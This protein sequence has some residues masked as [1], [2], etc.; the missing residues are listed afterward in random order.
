[1]LLTLPTVASGAVVGHWP[2]DGTFAD[3]ESNG[4]DLA[5]GAAPA[6]AGFASGRFGQAGSFTNDSVVAPVNAALDVTQY[7]VQA[8]FKTPDAARGVTPYPALA[9]RQVDADNRQLYLGW[10]VGCA[11]PQSTAFEYSVSSSDGSRYQVRIDGAPL[12]DGEWHHAAAVAEGTSGG[13]VLRLYVDGVLRGTTTGGGTIELQP[14]QGLRIGDGYHG[15]IDDIRFDDVALTA[16]V[17]QARY[18]ADAPVASG[19]QL[20]VGSC[21]T[22]FDASLFSTLLVGTP[23]VTGADCSIAFGSPDS[24]ATLRM[25]QADG[26]GSAMWQLAHGDSLDAAFGGG[27]PTADVAFGAEKSRA[28][29]VDA[30]R[31]RIYVAGET[32]N[33]G[34]RNSF[35]AA[36]QLSTGLPDTTFAGGDVN[37]SY[38]PG[39]DLFNDIV[40]QPD[41]KV[42]VVGTSNNG[43]NDDVLVV[44]YRQDGSTDTSFSTDGEIEHPLGTGQDEAATVDLLDDGRLVVAGNSRQGAEQD[45]FVMRLHPDGSFDRTF[46]SDGVAF[47]DPSTDEGSVSGRVQ[48]DGRIVLAGTAGS[49]LVAAR[50][51]TDGS[52]DTSYS[53]DGLV[54]VST[55]A[56]PESWEHVALTPDGGLVV[57]GFQNDGTRDN[58]AV[59]KLDAD[60]SLDAD[61]GSNGSVRVPNG[62]AWSYARDV[63][64]APQGEVVVAVEDG[65]GNHMITRLT[66]DGQLD[67]SFAGDGVYSHT[68]GTSGRTGGVA[69]GIDG[70]V[71]AASSATVGPESRTV[72]LMLDSSRIGDYEDGIADWDTAGVNAFGACIRRLSAATT[73]T[74]GVDAN[75]TCTSVDTDPWRSI[76]ATAADGGHLARTTVDGTG[77]AR[78][79]VRFGVRSK[80]GDANGEYIAPVVVEVAAPNL[81]PPVNIDL[82]TLS[83]TA[84]AKTSLG[85]MVGRWSGSPVI[86]YA[87]QWRRCDAAGTS[88]VDIPGATSR[89]FQLTP[90][91]VGLRVRVRVTAANGEGS[92]SADSAVSALVVA[93][94]TPQLIFNTGFEHGVVG[95]TAGSGRRLWDSVAG[96][97][98]QTAVDAFSDLVHSGDY[99][100]RMTTPGGTNTRL[101]INPFGTARRGVVR[102]AVNITRLPSV[103]TMEILQMQT[104]GGN[105]P[106]LEVYAD[107]RIAARAHTGEGTV[108]GNITIEEGRW[109]TIDLFLNTSTPTLT[110]DWMVDGRA[111]RQTSKAAAASDVTGLDLGVDDT[112]AGPSVEAYF[113]DLAIS[114]TAADYPLSYGMNIGLSPDWRIP[115]T[116][117]EGTFLMDGGLPLDGFSEI[118]RVADDPLTNNVDYVYQ[119]SAGGANYLEWTFTN[120][121]PWPSHNANGVHG[122]AAYAATASV[123]GNVRMVEADGSPQTPMLVANMSNGAAN[124]YSGLGMPV[125]T[126]GVWDSTEIADL[127]M[128]TGYATGTQARWHGLMYEVDYPAEYESNTARPTVSGVTRE[129]RDLTLSDGEWSGS[130][131]ALTYWWWRCDGSGRACTPIGATTWSNTYTLA[132][133]DV[134]TTI[135]GMVIATYGAGSTAVQQSVRTAATTVV[136]PATPTPVYL[137]GFETGAVSAAGSGTAT[138]SFDTLTGGAH[139][140]VVSGAPRTGGY[141]LKAEKSAATAA[142]ALYTIPAPGTAVTTRV[143][144]RLD[145]PSTGAEDAL[146]DL[147]DSTGSSF[148]FGV[149]WNRKRFFVDH[150]A[151]VARQYSTGIVEYG[152]WYVI[153]LRATAAVA[154][155]WR[156]DW[157]IDGAPQQT[158]VYTATASTA[159]QVSVAVGLPSASTNG[160][161]V[162]FDDLVVSKT[163]GDYPLGF[164]R[165]LGLRPNATGAHSL[166]VGQLERG[167]AGVGGAFVDFTTLPGSDSNQTGGTNTWNDLDDTPFGGVSDLIRQNNVAAHAE[168]QLEDTGT[169]QT[170]NAVRMV[171][172]HAEQAALGGN[173]AMGLVNL[174]GQVDTAYSIDPT[175]TASYYGGVRIARPAGAGGGPWTGTDVDQVRLR[176]GSSNAGSGATTRPLTHAIMLEADF[177]TGTPPFAVQN[178]SITFAGDY[179]RVGTALHATRGLWS[180]DVGSW[181]YEWERCNSAGVCTSVGS[182]QD[183]YSPAV[184]DLG[185]TIRV[186]VTANSENGAGSRRSVETPPIATAAPTLDW[187]TGFE[188]QVLAGAGGGVVTSATP[189]SAID[190]TIVRSGA[191][192]A[193]FTA[194]GA[195]EEVNVNL[196]APS[197]TVTRFALRV[198]QMPSAQTSIIE[199]PTA[200]LNKPR[201][202]LYPTGRLAAEVA[203]LSTPGAQIQ[204]GRWYVVDLRVDT[205]GATWS[206]DWR[207]DGQPMPTLRRTGATGTTMNALRFGVMSNVTSTVRFDDVAI[208]TNQYDYPIGDGKI[209]GYTVDSQGTHIDDVGRFSHVGGGAIDSTTHTRLDDVP[210]TSTADAVEQTLAHANSYLEFG[211]ANPAETTNP[212]AVRGVLA[213]RQSAASSLSLTARAVR[214][215][216]ADSAAVA[217][218]N[219]VATV[220]QTAQQYLGGMITAPS[221]GWTPAEL[222]ALRLRLGYFGTLPAQPRFQSVMV[223][224]EYPASQASPVPL[225]RPS[226]TGTFTAGNTLTV[227]DGTWSAAEDTSHSYQWLRCGPEGR[228]CTTIG[229]ANTRTYTVAA[230]DTGAMLRVRVTATSPTTGSTSVLSGEVEVV[231]D[232]TTSPAHVA[233]QAKNEAALTSA[234]TITKPAGTAQNHLMVATICTERGTTTSISGFPTGWRYLGRID[235]GTNVGCAHYWKVAGSAEP[236]NYTWNVSPA[237]RLVVGITTLSG[238][239]TAS[240]IDAFITASGVAAGFAVPAP[241]LTTTVANTTLLTVVGYNGAAVGFTPPAGMAERWDQNVGVGQTLSAEGAS[242]AIAAAGATGVRNATAST[243]GNQAYT[244]TS[245]A[246]RP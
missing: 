207:L 109:Y 85:A 36:F 29:A 211:L 2:L 50:L 246:I 168:Y 45:M 179:P 91:E 100:L 81:S 115:G 155:D 120:P 38:S 107:G 12:M 243:S 96:G 144:V 220:A 117:G 131:T 230:G 228:D 10:W 89:E 148:Q 129:G 212:R 199:F 31:D 238:A 78:V 141:S 56:S 63:F 14:A 185:Y 205:N 159:N 167:Q 146:V 76:P 99:A 112:A 189:G 192:S 20:D 126:S 208:S 227:S 51:L 122:A 71:V 82:P 169:T 142:S 225:V 7:T 39:D 181:S 86:R 8:W 69:L 137:N 118:G 145:T 21:R 244:G 23:A 57:A 127:T 16:D 195:F 28:V 242:Q 9:Q 183:S 79:D 17:V 190:T 102:F 54:N 241:S 187:L 165:I 224:A 77:Q 68:F 34:T 88:C 75:A 218:L 53:G 196:S 33:P 201:I 174:S 235:N 194:A 152:R 237:D 236:A 163:A 55:S 121:F 25:Y 6:D 135:R 95:T 206:I 176:I 43:S 216:D 15:A 98:Q 226:V 119:S 133:G 110:L 210:M 219:G 26:T 65:G 161:R 143:A 193:R 222:E 84:E 233:T 74:F 67:T 66:A 48:P 80:A 61:F 130:P 60:G 178:P 114:E 123:D 104:A 113:D 234:T 166:A 42:V 223:E 18:E 175:T 3:A 198:E 240:P 164:G 124:Q 97:G 103:G 11:C 13:F 92:A 4:L 182:S 44:R 58:V 93:A 106:G 203:G 200:D 231:R 59:A 154:N 147:K 171:G 221:G 186:T 245:I 191:A 134:G 116:P 188:H 170:A 162:Y 215:G 72:A 32:G 52:L 41:G 64:V 156:G 157:A 46:S 24:T 70:R 101:G 47:A 151:G 197:R 173:N 90:T 128:R 27:A 217:W 94:S 160:G 239:W 213:L 153:D 172:L 136:A 180:G 158:S 138:G 177:Q 22:G 87:Y 49:N 40:V 62:T 184:G 204:T 19:T 1:M 111:Q 232:T 214:D 5:N 150:G 229:G 105:T 139:L 73:S 108:F 132:S 30:P 125:P 209:I 140:S 83:G 35:V 37:I 149:N 202:E